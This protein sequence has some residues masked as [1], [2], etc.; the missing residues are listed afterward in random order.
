MQ[1]VFGNQWMTQSLS[2]SGRDFNKDLVCAIE[3]WG[4]HKEGIREAWRKAGESHSKIKE[5]TEGGQIWEGFWKWDFCGRQ[6]ASRDPKNWQSIL[7]PAHS[8]KK[9][10]PAC[11]QCKNQRHGI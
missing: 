5:M 3:R 1:R 7:P 9:Y 8:K 4:E 10:P 2:H 11:G 6:I